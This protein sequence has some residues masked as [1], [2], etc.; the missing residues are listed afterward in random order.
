MSLHGDRRGRVPFALV[1]VLLL[2]GASVYATGIAE[3][4]EPSIEHPTSAAMD[5]L[6]RDTRPALRTA[7]RDAARESA[8]NPVTQAADTP[9]GRA[10][11]ATSPFVDALR[12]R[13]A[14]AAREALAGVG[15]EQDGVRATVSL[16]AVNGSTASLRRAKRGIQ[17]RPVDDGASM[18]VTVR[19][20]TIRARADG[21]VL[22]QRRLNVTLTVDTPVLALHH[23]TEQYESRLNRGALA[24]PGLS[25]SLTG[26]LTALTVARGYGRYAGAP[27]Q[28][29]L[30]NRHVEL[31]TNAALLAQQRA[32]FGRRD[33]DGARA[34]DVATVRVGVLD[35]LGGRHD[36]AAGWTKTVLDPSAVGS[37]PEDDGFDPQPP[38]VSPIT[39]APDAAADQAFLDATAGPET[40]G[41]YQV[42]SSLRAA[43]LSRSSGTR[44]EPRLTNWTLLTERTD[45]RT[46]V[47]AIDGTPTDS[48]SAPIDAR[49]KVTV[50]HTV[51]RTWYRKGSFRTTT[52]EWT[53]TARVAVRVSVAYDP[54]DAASDRPTE[55]LFERGGA[56]DGPNLAGVRERAAAELLAANGGIDGVAVAAAERQGGSLTRERTSVAPRPDGLDAWVLGDLRALRESVANV[57]VTVP[58][59]EIAAGEAN[60]PALL[61]DAVRERR[62]ALID[63]PGAYDGAADRARVAARAV[64]VERVIRALEARAAETRDRNVDYRSELAGRAT[65][66][67]SKLIELGR[68]T[69]SGGD[70]PYRRDSERTD[71]LE[72]TPDGS[73]AYL[74]LSSV[75]HEHVPSVAPDESVHPLTARTTNWVAM[76][77]GDAADSV[78]DVLLGGRERRV[79]LETAAATLIA[80]NRTATAGESANGSAAALASNRA[81]LTAAVRRS[82]RRTERAVCVAATEETVLEQHTCRGVVVDLR[83]Q[84]PTLGHRAQA[85]GNGSYAAV[86]G[87]ALAVRGVDDAAADEA[88]VRVRVRLR[89]RG[90][91]RETGVPA[92]TT[93]RTASAVRQVARRTVEKQA[94]YVIQNG[95]ERA[96]RRLTGVSRLP[97]GVPVAPPPYTWIASVNAWSVTVRG[98]YQRF[99]VR[100]RGPAPDGGGG[101][102]RYVRDGSAV[103]FDADGDSRAE[104]LGRNER[105]SFEASTTVVAVV[106]PGPPGIGDVDGNRD[107]RSP[108]WPCPGK[109]GTEDCTRGGPE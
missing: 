19:N 23:R 10:L 109:V 106:P 37:D 13:I 1:G 71:E 59:R 91:K 22:T 9:A 38:D 67:L 11:N 29:V 6:E 100:A 101:V 90:S 49:R 92:A 34:V 97:A 78:A 42:R 20:V 68:E 21:R 80:A 63:A 86:F 107:E 46:T 89:E 16:P 62:E 45:E 82:V 64:Y 95:S 77:Y 33:P 105:V 104:R 41:S 102:V 40:A 93:N 39:A 96:M 31:S 47:E 81:A 58:R 18:I 65:G 32:T 30:G 72:I 98:E 25:R 99:A 75:G 2:L 108:G 14:A 84:W 60:A 44:P 26:R 52:A 57:S 3:R 85:M 70:D 94:K 8:R 51:E 27:I 74:T 35:V 36:G 5:D 15:R 61:A 73:P 103:E 55:P 50:H 53:E 54:D 69:A 17:V 12:L 87:E 48:E 43:V 79:T 76:P 83:S 28:N 88:T 4:A 66:G 56:L 7:V 24:G